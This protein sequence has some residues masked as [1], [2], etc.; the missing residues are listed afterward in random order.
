MKRF[1]ITLNIVTNGKKINAIKDL[2]SATGIG[3]GDSKFFVEQRLTPDIY[4]D[5]FG[6]DMI[7]NEQ[8][9]AALTVLHF[10][11]PQSVNG[12]G[13]RGPTFTITRCE[14]IGGGGAL[15]ASG[16]VR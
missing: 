15:D 11:P 14:T 6:G 5:S 9:L 2:R 4:L 13:D 12:Y 16:I 7:V 3:L 10:A 1:L 8:Q